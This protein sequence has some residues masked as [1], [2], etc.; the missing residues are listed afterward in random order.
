MA[1]VLGWKGGEKDSGSRSYT[2]RT[3]AAI[4]A[5]FSKTV[6]ALYMIDG[7]GDIPEIQYILQGI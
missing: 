6:I 1:C 5:A 4:D 2:Y 7:L 3:G